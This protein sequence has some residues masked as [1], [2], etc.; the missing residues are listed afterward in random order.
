MRMNMVAVWDK[1]MRGIENIRVRNL[2][3]VRLATVQVLLCH[4]IR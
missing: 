2:A 3:V 1:A 4:E